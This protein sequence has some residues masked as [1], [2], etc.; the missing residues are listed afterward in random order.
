[1]SEGRDADRREFCRKALGGVVL[2]AMAAMAG[3]L[4][5]RRQ[6]SPPVSHRCLQESRCW[7]CGVYASCVLPQAVTRRRAEGKG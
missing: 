2:G 3:M 1:M 4:V 7:N 6:V 5:R